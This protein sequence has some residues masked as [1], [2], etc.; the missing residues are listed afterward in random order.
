MCSCFNQEMINESFKQSNLSKI[1]EENF[2]TFDFGYYSTAYNKEKYGIDK[3]PLENIDAIRKIAFKFS[4]CLEDPAQK[5]LLF[6]GVADSIK[7][8]VF[9]PA[10]IT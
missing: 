9:T 7:T 3:S 5:N 8:L 6:T 2:E 10:F 1:K 4:H